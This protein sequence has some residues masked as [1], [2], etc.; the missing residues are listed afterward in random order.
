MRI[1]IM[2]AMVMEFHVRWIQVI[3]TWLANY[4]ASCGD[5][6]ARIT[7]EHRLHGSDPHTARQRTASQPYILCTVYWC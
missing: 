6:A 7:T 1:L 2:E 4:V 5:A 3:V